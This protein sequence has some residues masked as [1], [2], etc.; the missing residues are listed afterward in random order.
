[1]KV[2]KL[3]KL[4]AIPS[5]PTLE[6]YRAYIIEAIG[7]NR[8]EEIIFSIDAKK[9]A[10]ILTEL[11]PLRKVTGN[12]SGPLP[13]GPHFLVIPPDK[14]YK[15]AGA[16]VGWVHLVGKIIELAVG[17][18]LPGEYLSRFAAQHNEYLTCLEGA[19]VGTGTT[20]A[21]AAEITLKSITPTTIEQY[22]FNN[23]FYV[24]QIAA[25]DVAEADGDVGV[26]PY[27]DGVPFDI[28][29]SATGK[30]GLNRFDLEQPVSSATYSEVPFT[31]EDSPILVPG[32]KTLDIKAM[33]VSGAVLFKT[34][35]AEFHW[36]GAAVYKKAA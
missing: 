4:V 10:S 1:M 13:L 23:R 14:T 31:L 29:K 33:N 18:T 21:D 24:K 7:T 16:T 3:D 22:T 20:W 25:G 27:L 5:E 19:D 32:D 12:T 26:R 2:Y 9:V 11:A 36:F 28:I 15:T 8:T 34:T 35:Q 30:R 17:E 6:P